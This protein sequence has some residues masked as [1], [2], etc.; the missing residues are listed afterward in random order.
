MDIACDIGYGQDVVKPVPKSSISDSG[1][2][3]SVVSNVCHTCFE[4]L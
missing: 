4:L 3:T 1:V 2:G